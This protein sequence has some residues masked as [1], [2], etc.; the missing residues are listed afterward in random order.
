MNQEEIN[1]SSTPGGQEAFTTL[2][3]AEQKRIADD[4]AT[5]AYYVKAEIA[6]TIPELSD[7]EGMKKLAERIGDEETVARLAHEIKKIMEKAFAEMP[8]EFQDKLRNV[9]SAVGKLVAQKGTF[10]HKSPIEVTAFNTQ[11]LEWLAHKLG[12]RVEA[13]YSLSKD[14]TVRYV[15]GDPRRFPG[16]YNRVR[17]GVM[18]DSGENRPHSYDYTLIKAFDQSKYPGKSRSFVHWDVYDYPSDKD[19]IQDA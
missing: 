7:I 4:A 8:K 16:C 11:E 13:R 19:P 9:T 1:Y 5:E 10:V 3:S 17:L 14:D 6:E 12:G 15:E 18:E 2:P